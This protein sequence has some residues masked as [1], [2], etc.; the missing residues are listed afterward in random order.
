[1]REQDGDG[2]GQRTEK[3]E[4]HEVAARLFAV[5]GGAEDA[6]ADDAAE[7]VAQ[8]AGEENSGGEKCGV[9]EV[10]PVAVQEKRGYPGEIK[11]ERPAV[12]KIDYGDRE[13]AAREAA[14]GHGL[15][16]LF[17]AGGVGRKR[18]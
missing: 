10:E 8:D 14:P 9:A 11:P 3:A 15:F 2:R 4:N 1:M 7:R 16:F 5:A 17:G 13:H 12:A 18:S 6:V